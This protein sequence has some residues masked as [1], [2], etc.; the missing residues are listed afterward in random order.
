[1]AE[2]ERPDDPPARRPL[3]TSPGELCGGKLGDLPDSQADRFRPRLRV[4]A[5]TMDHDNAARIRR[6]VSTVQSVARRYRVPAHHLRVLHDANNVVL[7]LVPSLVVAKVSLSEGTEA[8]GRLA[9]EVAVGRHLARAGAPV[10]GPCSDLPPGP[11]AS[12]GCAITFWRHHDHD[13]GASACGRLAAEVLEQVHRA[14][15]D[16]PGPVRS[17]LERRLISARDR[18]NDMPSCGRVR[19]RTPPW[20]RHSRP[21]SPRRLGRT[22]G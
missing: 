17:F 14:L 4:G 22:S 13:P 2:G 12:G 7:H 21:R 8:W 19:R 6:A 20:S 18:G 3:G 5:A 10:V 16:Y 15:E 1:M 9:A 11:H